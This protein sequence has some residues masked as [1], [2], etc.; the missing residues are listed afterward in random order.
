MVMAGGTNP[1]PLARFGVGFFGASVVTAPPLG[2]RI[3]ASFFTVPEAETFD[4]GIFFA[5]VSAWALSVFL[6]A[7][8]EEDHILKSLLTSLGIPGVV[9]SL[10]I[11]FQAIR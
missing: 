8:M 5:L 1:G 2:Q 7:Y 11:G 6:T 4:S 9:V 10:S 3:Q